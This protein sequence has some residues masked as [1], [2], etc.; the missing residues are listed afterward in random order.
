MR[1]VGLPVLRVRRLE[2]GNDLGGTTWMQHK[3]Q[4]ESRTGA[5]GC[6]VSGK[7]PV[8]SGEGGVW[9]TEGAGGPKLFGCRSVT[10][11]R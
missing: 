2:K 8:R 4:Q 3:D 5:V 1:G 6:E 9:V 7:G 10:P 11:S